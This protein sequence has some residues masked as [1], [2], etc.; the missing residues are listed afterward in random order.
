M[1]LVLVIAAAAALAGCAGDGPSTSDGAVTPGPTPA[2]GA[3]TIAQLEQQIFTPN[4]LGAGCHNAGDAGGSLVL[5]PGLAWR[6]L[7]GVAT[8]NVAAANAGWQRAVPFDLER[9]F[10]VHKL[11]PIS[12]GFGARMPLSRPPLSEQDIELIRRWIRE[13][14]A[15]RQ[16]PSPTPLSTATATDVPTA[17]ITPSPSPSSTVTDTPT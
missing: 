1:R 5:E 7:V 13:G 10:L 4:C 16:G 12:G 6:Q 17:T 14:A 2:G 9:S 8:E 15:D 3:V 11:L